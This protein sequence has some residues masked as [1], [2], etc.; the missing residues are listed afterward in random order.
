MFS[1]F[2]IFNGCNT[3][4]ALDFQLEK[5]QATKKDNSFKNKALHYLYNFEN[6]IK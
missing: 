1:Q 6:F 4:D 5:Y 3:E 2:N